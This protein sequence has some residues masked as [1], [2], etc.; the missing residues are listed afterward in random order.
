[1]QNT[2]KYC[3][4]KCWL[5]LYCSYLLYSFVDVKVRQIIGM[6]DIRWKLIK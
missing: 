1:M 5:V 2:G 4:F 3:V 6:E